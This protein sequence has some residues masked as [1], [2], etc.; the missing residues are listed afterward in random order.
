ME[1]VPSK[2][3][4]VVAH[5]DDEIIGTGGTIS[6]LHSEGKTVKVIVFHL[7]GESVRGVL[8]ETQGQDVRYGELEEVSK[9]LGFAHE[10][11]GIRDV[12]DR[13]DVVKKLVKEM[14]DFRPDL[15]FTHAPQDRHHLHASVSS[16]TTEAAWHAS[17]LY[18]LDLGKPWRTS[19]VY[20]FEVWDLFTS[21]SFLVDMTQFMEKKKRAMSLY[22]SQLTAFPRIM[23]YVEALAIVRGVEAGSKYAEAFQR[24]PV[25]P[26]IR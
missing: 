22:A 24:A 19:S 3:L 18:Y 15:V 7:G 10:S 16:T 6:K 8:D 14:R 26:Q 5:P 13:R 17:Q 1:S 12:A 2:V 25:L 11:W 21:P 4:V 20:Y 9:Y 23:E